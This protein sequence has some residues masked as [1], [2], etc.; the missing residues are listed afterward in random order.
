VKRIRRQVA[1]LFML[2]QKKLWRQFPF[3]EGPIIG[4]DG[5][6]FDWEFS[7]RVL[8]AGR[9]IALIKGL[10]LLHYYRMQEGGK[11]YTEHLKT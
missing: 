11:S 3:R 1:G 7:T 5:Q 6:Y 10:Y 2:F 9:S 4:E 8:R